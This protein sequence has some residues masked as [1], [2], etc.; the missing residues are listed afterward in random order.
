VSYPVLIGKDREDV[1]EAL[2][3]LLGFH[4]KMPSSTRRAF[5]S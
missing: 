4:M 3:P 1:T 2:G 5:V